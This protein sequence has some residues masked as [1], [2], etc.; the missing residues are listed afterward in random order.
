MRTLLIA[1]LF[2]LSPVSATPAHAA[3]AA[4]MAP[5]KLSM[6]NKTAASELSG[7]LNNEAY[8]A[9]G[10]TKSYDDKLWDEIRLK[11]VSNGYLPMIT[12]ESDEDIPTSVVED[13][14]YGQM[15][16]LPNYMSGAKAVVK[17]GGG[18][19]PV[20]GLPYNDVYYYLDLTV[21]YATFTQRMY[22]QKEEGRT[23]LAF[24]NVDEKIVGA[25]TWAKYTEI[26]TKT[27]EGINRRWPPFNSVVPV[28]EVYGMFIV[29][30]GETKSARVTFV[31]KLYFGESA[32][33]IAK[34][35]SQLPF[36]L[37]AGLKSGF[38]AS[39]KIAKAERDRQG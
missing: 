19:D 26:M 11:E 6:H 22:I 35:G 25:E 39:V 24:E 36:V 12:G 17:L 9:D 1:F 27:N 21:F 18:V 29:T 2:A 16:E 28:D 7:V 14:V 32:G 30:P 8:W 31:S 15:T 38:A 4:A 13:I 5:V 10:W 3:D 37:K 20:L 23:V 33:W 34:W